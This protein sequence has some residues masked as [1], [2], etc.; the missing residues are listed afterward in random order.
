[1]WFSHLSKF[2]FIVV[3]SRALSPDAVWTHRDY[4]AG[5]VGEGLELVSLR[6][7]VH[8]NNLLVPLKGER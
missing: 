6:V 7:F 5:E 4:E 3:G 1:M 8:V 2:S